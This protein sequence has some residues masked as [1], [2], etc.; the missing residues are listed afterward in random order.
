[1]ERRN[2]NAGEEGNNHSENAVTVAD[3]GKKIDNFGAWE[4]RDM[5][6]G[7]QNQR[8]EWR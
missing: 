6:K 8:Q 7:S 3:G 5:C 4:G 2:K 1:M